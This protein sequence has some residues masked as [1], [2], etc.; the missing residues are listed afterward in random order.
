MNLVA[1]VMLHISKASSVFG[2]LSKRLWQDYSIKLHT[3][4]AVYRAVV[5]RALLY[6]CGTWATYSR[7]I[8]KLEQFHQCF[9]RKICSIKWQERVSNLQVLKKCGLPS[10]E[11]I[12]IKSQ[13][14]RTM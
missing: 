6:C 14:R 8:K 2:R 3:K 9:L 12:L 1:E 4:V 11:R 10:I 5:L 13:L 7:H